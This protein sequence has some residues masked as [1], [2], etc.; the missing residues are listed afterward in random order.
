MKIDRIGYGATL[1][2][3]N[4]ESMKLYLEAEIESWEDPIEC[5]NILKQKLLET[6]RRKEEAADYEERAE[7][8]ERRVSNANYQLEKA[9]KTWQEIV[10]AKEKAIALLES[11]GVGEDKLSTI[12]Y[13]F[14]STPSFDP[15]KINDDD[16]NEYGV[17]DIPM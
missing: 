9:K 3:G 11:F 2:T 13:H 7:R 8:A 6:V 17:D 10:D 16:D 4:Y 1:N 5:I 14:P 12:K 15:V